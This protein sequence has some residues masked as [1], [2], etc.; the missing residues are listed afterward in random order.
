VEETPVCLLSEDAVKWTGVWALKAANIGKD[1]N[2][3]PDVM[4]ILDKKPCNDLLPK[5]GRVFCCGLAYDYCVMDTAVNF[6]Q[7]VVDF[8]DNKCFM[9]QDLTRAA[10]IPGIGA[11]GS[12][13]LTDPS[14]LLEGLTAN[15]IG[16]VR[17]VD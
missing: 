10:R 3:S 15:K 12:G 2:A 7:T 17:F 11:F 1:A 9:V 6:V 4:S 16:L 8:D 13:F 5:G 14:V